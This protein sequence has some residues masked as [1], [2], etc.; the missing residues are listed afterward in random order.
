MA[1]LTISVISM[2]TIS[3]IKLKPASREPAARDV[4]VICLSLIAVALDSLCMAYV[5]PAF[6][7]VQ[8]R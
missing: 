7:F 6:R 3:S 1:P 8:V 4:L 5:Q 2:A